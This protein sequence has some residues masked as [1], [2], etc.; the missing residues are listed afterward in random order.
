MTINN[1]QKQ[2][3]DSGKPKEY[4]GSKRPM[5]LVKNYKTRQ[6]VENAQGRIDKRFA[7][8][9]DRVGQIRK[10]YNSSKTNSLTKQDLLHENNMLAEE[11]PKLRESEE[12]LK[13]KFAELEEEARD[14]LDGLTLETVDCN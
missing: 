8:V 11:M 6:A 3:V 13:E 7:W 14:N 4:D 5:L 10:E 1:D 9:K 2:N 12:N